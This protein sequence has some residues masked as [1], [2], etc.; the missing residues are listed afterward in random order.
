M[1][2]NNGKKRWENMSVPDPFK[3]KGPPDFNI[4]VNGDFN[5]DM[6]WV[7]QIILVYSNRC[8]S[9]LLHRIIFVH[10]LSDSEFYWLQVDKCFNSIACGNI[11]VPSIVSTSAMEQISNYEVCR[12]DWAWIGSVG[13][14]I[15][16]NGCVQHPSTLSCVHSRKA[17]TLKLLFWNVQAYF[18]EWQIYITPFVLIIINHI[19]FLKILKSL[20]KQQ[21][22]MA[23]I[24]QFVMII[25][26]QKRHLL[27]KG[28]QMVYCWRYK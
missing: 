28:S 3:K 17:I 27:D 22:A 10:S 8:I 13:L 5:I 6:A 21:Q 16:L 14:C 19:N 26:L 12:T 15:F 2:K 11:Y 9:G 20:Q 25:L 23:D 18:I 7:M 1:S 24:F 4:V